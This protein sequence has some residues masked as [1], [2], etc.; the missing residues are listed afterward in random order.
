MI[1]IKEYSNESIDAIINMILDIQTEEFKIQIDGKSQPDLYSI[2][3]FYQTDNG[4][5]WV[6]EDNSEII[7]T[8]ALKDIGD[9][10]GALRKMFVKKEYR[11]KGKNISRL[12]L[13][14]VFHWGRVK[15]FEKIFLGT[16][17]RFIAAHR[18]YEKNGFIEITDSEL[19]EKFPLM[20]VDSKF[21]VYEF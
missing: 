8:V 1:E 7:G 3:D 19:P 10:Y 17:D 16:T 20:K 18:F 12:L 14:S 5:F 15:G 9:N 21:Y 2:K 4:N 11:G 6:A 13:E